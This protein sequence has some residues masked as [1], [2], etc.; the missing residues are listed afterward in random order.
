MDLAHMAGWVRNKF[1]LPG[2]AKITVG[3]ALTTVRVGDVQVTLPFGVKD[4][5]NNSLLPK[6]TVDF[7]SLFAKGSAMSALKT[8][9]PSETVPPSTTMPEE[10]WVDA[11]VGTLFP[12]H[13]PLHVCQQLYQTVPGTSSKSVYRVAFVGPHLK[14]AVRLKSGS[15][16]FRFTT[17]QAQCPT[18]EV[19]Q[20]LKHLGIDNEYSDRITGHAALAADIHSD[21][22]PTRALFGAFYGALRPYL[23]SP[24]PDLMK[25]AEGVQ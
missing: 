1:N 22:A 24:F 20:T 19:L 18:G 23:T 16:S 14:G 4:V 11:V 15:C 10:D 5:K 13:Q 6:T 3:S 9:A 25:F 17:D 2:D 21:P 12:N 8:S 7:W